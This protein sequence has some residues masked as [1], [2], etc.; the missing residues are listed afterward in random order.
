MTK[1]YNRY[2]NTKSS[3]ATTAKKTNVTTIPTAKTT[4][5][6]EKTV[7]QKEKEAELQE[8][9][10]AQ[11]TDRR[12][13]P[14]SYDVLDKRVTYVT[15]KNGLFKVTKTPIGLF[16]ELMQAFDTEI[17]GLPAMEAGVDLAIPKIPFKYILEALSFYRDINTKDKTEASTLYFWNHR[18][19]E[20]PELP[21][22]RN[23]GQL[24]IYCP[25]QK[26]SSALSEFGDDENVDWMRENL[27]L[28]LELHSH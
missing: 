14:V 21:G 25:V 16:K 8:I 22:L 28:L 2:Q 5:K 9:V 1:K 11:M 23:E 27:A 24:V 18:N 12:F 17:V 19:L 13:A 10:A 4:I 15:A 7:Q 26:N 3:Q 20:L 6:K